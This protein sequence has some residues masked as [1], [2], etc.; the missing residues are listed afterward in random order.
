MMPAIPRG[1]REEDRVLG[2]QP[3]EGLV[4]ERGG[5]PAPLDHVDQGTLKL[6]VDTSEIKILPGKY[7]LLPAPP[8]RAR[9]DNEELVDWGFAASQTDL[10]LLVRTDTGAY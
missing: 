8:W 3:E 7:H 1:E 2:R 4:E 9:L 5:V 10:S 6:S